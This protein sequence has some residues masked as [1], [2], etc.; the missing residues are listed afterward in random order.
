M[1]AII[2]CRLSAAVAVVCVRHA[3]VPGICKETAQE[4]DAGWR[5]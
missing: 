4:V 5:Q 1:A 3:G 2:V